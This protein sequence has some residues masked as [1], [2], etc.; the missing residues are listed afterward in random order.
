MYNLNVFQHKGIGKSDNFSSCNTPEDQISLV[1]SNFF[2]VR[3]NVKS[4]TAMY[5]ELKNLYPIDLAKSICP[6]F[7]LQL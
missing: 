2:D 1:G 4:D 7:F 5:L 3:L 6:T